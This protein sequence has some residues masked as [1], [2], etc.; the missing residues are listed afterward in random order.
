[1]KKQKIDSKEVGLE[2]GL[3]LLKFFAKTDFL[4]YGY[5]EEGMEVDIL[6]LK[7]AQ[8]NYTDFLFSHIPQGTKSILDVGC[9]SGKIARML[10]DKGYQVDGVSPAE[11]LTERAREA[12]GQEGTIY[13]GTYEEVA[14]P[15]GKTYDLILFSESFQYINMPRNFERSYQLLNEGGYMLLCDFFRYEEHKH[16]PLGGGHWLGHYEPALANS[17]FEVVTEIDIT[18]KVAPT[19]DL[20]NGLTMEV[21][22]PAWEMGTALAE[23]RLP[24]WVWRI[25][26]WKFGKKM[27]DIEAKQFKG[28]RNAKNFIADKKYCLI[29]LKKK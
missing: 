29:L 9:G 16:R 6:N 7:Q 18:Q 14:I 8:Q 19:M 28:E 21:M 15:E 11:R 20:V 1:M 23:A 4:H 2:I 24:G 5:W 3:S 27:L 25:I 26:K 17:K 13:H 10:L 12:V 22:K